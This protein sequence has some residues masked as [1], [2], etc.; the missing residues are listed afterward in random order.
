MDPNT[1]HQL[2]SH[3]TFNV[4]EGG[5]RQQKSDVQ[6]NARIWLRKGFGSDGR[7][8]VI[9]TL[10][11]WRI[12]AVVEGVPAHDPDYVVSVQRG[13]S[14]FVIQGWGILASGTVHVRVLAGDE[15]NGKPPSQVVMLPA[16]P[17]PTPPGD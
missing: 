2:W 7:A 8:R 3:W 4:H 1:Q 10:S 5:T 14:R 6:R 17:L 13:F 11:G 16:I 15:Q 12:E 9:A